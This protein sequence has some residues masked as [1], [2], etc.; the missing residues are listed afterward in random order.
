MVNGVALTGDNPRYSKKRRRRR[1]HT[2]PIAFVCQ[3]GKRL[4][5]KDETAGRRVRCPNCGGA[6][7]VPGS[8]AERAV[9]APPPP[10]P[11]PPQPAAPPPIPPRLIPANH[12]PG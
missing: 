3:C 12:G 6:L 4:S 7:I 5:S 1:N 9:K 2:M 8:A 10:P 11:P